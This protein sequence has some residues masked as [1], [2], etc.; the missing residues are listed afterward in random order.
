MKIVAHSAKLEFAPSYNQ[1]LD[2]VTSAG[3]TCYKS[4]NQGTPENQ[5]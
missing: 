5:E 4:E 2:V 1:I 3:R